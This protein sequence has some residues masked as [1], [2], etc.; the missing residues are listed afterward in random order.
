MI[1][2]QA[3]V[4]GKPNEEVPNML[5]KSFL[6]LPELY[7]RFKACGDSM[8]SRILIQGFLNVYKFPDPE[9]LY[10]LIVSSERQA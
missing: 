8:N 6:K 7:V 10:F 4:G 2:Q 1:V 3:V 5:F 9:Y